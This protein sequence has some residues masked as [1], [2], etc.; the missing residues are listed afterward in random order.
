MTRAI[1][2]S[3]IVTDMCASQAHSRE[4]PASRQTYDP[5]APN[6]RQIHSGLN[7]QENVF[8]LLGKELRQTA[9]ETRPFR[10]LTIEVH[11][12]YGSKCEKN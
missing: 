5:I 10:R 12:N 9:L 6:L 3:Q 1:E 11:E 8:L 2:T 4:F 7:R